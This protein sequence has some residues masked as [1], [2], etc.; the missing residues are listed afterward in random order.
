MYPTLVTLMKAELNDFADIQVG[1]Q[2]FGTVKATRL[3]N[4]LHS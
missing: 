4:L 1:K 3:Y 2:K